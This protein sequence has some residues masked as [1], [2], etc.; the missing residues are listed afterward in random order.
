MKQYFGFT[1]I[2][3]YLLF[4]VHSLR[5]FIQKAQEKCNIV[6]YVTYFYVHNGSDFVTKLYLTLVTP[7]TVACLPGF[8]AHE[9][10]QAR[11]LEWVAKSFS[12]G[13]SRPRDQSQVSCIPGRFFII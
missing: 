13:S 11:I 4:I 12:K 9:I 1:F 3:C 2:K 7:W 8:S 5:E 6:V 10:L